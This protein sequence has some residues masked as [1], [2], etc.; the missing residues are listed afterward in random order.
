MLMAARPSNGV[1]AVCAHM[2]Q[3]RLHWEPVGDLAAI[4][5][6][7]RSVG[8][9]HTK[10]GLALAEG[11]GLAC[12]PVRWRPASCVLLS[13]AGAQ[14]VVSVTVEPHENLL[15]DA[16][17][18]AQQQAAPAQDQYLVPATQQ[19]QPQSP[20][21]H[22]RNAQ[23]LKST[24][25]PGTPQS[26]G[27]C[28]GLK[29]GS[30]TVLTEGFDFYASPRLSPDGTQLAWVAWRHPNMPWSVLSF[31]HFVTGCTLSEQCTMAAWGGP[32]SSACVHV[33][34]N[35]QVVGGDW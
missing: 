32:E 24:L 35:V 12:A 27:L 1:P 17:I 6:V 26:R 5:T 3:H 4:I 18:R 10:G 9:A 16:A 25:L 2:V 13:Q 14:P 28:A 11:L 21:H 34:T 19:R 7:L 8:N 15:P 22:T 29:D 20:D 33:N 31:V 23:T 30:E